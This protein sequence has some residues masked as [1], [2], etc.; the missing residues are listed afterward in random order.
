MGWVRIGRRVFNVSGLIL[1]EWSE[2]DPSKCEVTL[3]SGRTFTL[4][5]AESEAFGDYILG[6]ESG[7]EVVDLTP[8]Q[9]RVAR[10]YPTTIVAPVRDQGVAQD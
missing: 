9:P 3:P 6:G 4:A 8:D 5:G 2:D 10:A 1:A 7:L